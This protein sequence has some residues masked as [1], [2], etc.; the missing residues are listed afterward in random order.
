M[1]AALRLR[2]LYA[3]LRLLGSPVARGLAASRSSCVSSSRACVVPLANSCRMAATSAQQDAAGIVVPKEEMQAFIVRCMRKVCTDEAHAEALAEVLVAG[4]YRGHF[5]HGLN[6]L[7]MYVTDI[8]KGVCERSGK[9]VV[10]NELAATALVDGRNVLGPVVGKFCMELAMQ[11][12][13]QAG[14]GWVVAR[15]SNHYGIA[16]YYSMMASSR[17][18]IGMSFTNASPLVAPSGGRKKFLGTNPLSVAAPGKDGDSFVLDMA[19]SAVA[20]GKVE[21]QHRKGEQIPSGWAI[22]GQGEVTN[23]PEEVMSDGALLPLGGTIETSGYKG[24]GLAMMVDLFCGVLSSAHYGNN[25]RSWLNVTD[26][27]DLGQCFVA[28]N[29]AA[30]APGFE[31]RMQDLM[32]TARSQEP[33]TPGVPVQVPGD[34]ERKHMAKCDAQGGIRYHV[35]Q[36]QFADDIAQKLCVEPPKRK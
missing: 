15:G 7:Q 30:F 19:T 12:A 6:R 9:P 26:P 35:N 32:N 10:I 17:G 1:P 36:I 22:N 11:K 18:M 33:A 34:P 2:G 13:Q 23:K 27:A 25:I 31:G 5:S 8:Q 28:I 21:M 16:G 14:I 4:D 20:L 24:Y 29:P 3:R